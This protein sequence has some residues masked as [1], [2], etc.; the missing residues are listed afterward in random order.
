MS[1]KKTWPFFAWQSILHTKTQKDFQQIWS[2]KKNWSASF[3]AGR[4]SVADELP[5]INF[6]ARDYLKQILRPDF[7]VFEFG[8][9]GST[10]YFCK[11]V[12]EVITVEDNPEWFKILTETL[13]S[14]G[15]TNWQG[16]FV[17]AEVSNDSGPRSHVNPADFKSSNR[18][19]EN[20]SFE[21]YARTI[22]QFPEAYFDLILVDGRARPSCTQQAIPHLKKGGF[23]V[24]DNTER[25]HYL[26][27]F[28]EVIATQFTVEENRIGPIAYT[29]DFTG[30][31]ILR[32][33]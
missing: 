8:G 10:L 28:K 23:L 27:H 4:N 24:V 21:K 3:A 31:T 11:H 5:W 30:T 9:G 13:Q 20:M 32:K 16:F 19:L 1:W 33:K 2:N 15:Y 18:S 25:P 6:F 7:K 26:A 22:G 17:P 29:P 12:A 14:K